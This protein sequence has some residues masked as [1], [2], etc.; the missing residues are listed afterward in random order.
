MCR[1]LE[2]VEVTGEDGIPYMRECECRA[3]KHSLKRLEES[4]L[5]ESIEKYTFDNYNAYAPWVENV[6]DQAMKYVEDHDGKWL[7]LGGQVGAGKT[8]LCT[9]VVGELIRQGMDARYLMWRDD[10]VKIKAL[11]TK[12]E[13][14]RAVIEPLKTV[15]VLYI[16]DLFKT[17]KGRNPTSGDINIA[18][19]LLNYRY[20]NSNLITIISSE[21][22]IDQ[23]IDVDEAVGSRIYE[24]TR[25]NCVCI[26]SKPGRNYRLMRQV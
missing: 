21:R 22:N 16:D 5:K 1:D 24:R 6:K 14:Y 23:I 4:G 25:G 15:K 20:V 8:H 9:A 26:D 17:D 11:V 13:E 18:F 3:K 12:D 7:F 19:E 2:Y 10:V